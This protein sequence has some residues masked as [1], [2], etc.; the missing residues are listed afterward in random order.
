MNVVIRK[1]ERG[2]FLGLCWVSDDDW[3]CLVPR[4]VVNLKRTRPEARRYRN[5]YQPCASRNSQFTTPFGKWL[6]VSCRCNIPGCLSAIVSRTVSSPALNFLYT[7]GSSSPLPI[8]PHERRNS[9]RRRRR[10]YPKEIQRVCSVLWSINID[11][12]IEKHNAPIMR[13]SYFIPTVHLFTASK[14][15]IPLEICELTTGHWDRAL[16]VFSENNYFL[17]RLNTPGLLLL[18]LRVWRYF[19]YDFL[20]TRGDP[21]QKV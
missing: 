2:S 5:R 18:S 4:R 1:P 11:K 21:S 15:N 12:P 7:L 10:K 20:I 16:H 8:Y 19:G 14:F 17:I 13:G 6:L 9:R 3:P